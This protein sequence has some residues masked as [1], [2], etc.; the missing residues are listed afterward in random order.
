VVG[1][2]I[3]DGGWP[4]VR[5]D[6]AGPLRLADHESLVGAMERY[7]GRERRFAVVFGSRPDGRAE[8]GLAKVQFD[9]LRAEADR[10]ARW[11][12][13]WAMVTGSGTDPGA[14]ER[15]RGAAVDALMPFPRYVADSVDEAV[16]W[17]AGQLAEVEGQLDGAGGR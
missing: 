16:T 1:V 3:D 6:Y 10:L 4:L 15:G 14:G 2:T 13:G 17:A 8:S 5:V 11:C 9:W 12:A 7:L